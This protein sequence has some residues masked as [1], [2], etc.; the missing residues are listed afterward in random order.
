M[1]VCVF[2][3]ECVVTPKCIK[4]ARCCWL[5]P[6]V[7]SNHRLQGLSADGALN[8]GHKTAQNVTSS[9]QRAE[10]VSCI[11]KHMCCV[12]ST[13][14]GVISVCGWTGCVVPCVNGVVHVFE[15]W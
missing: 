15:S 10:P 14:F 12:Y 5:W 7:C 11:L 3:P 6:S 13:E 4:V 1:Y 9:S 2:V 8:T